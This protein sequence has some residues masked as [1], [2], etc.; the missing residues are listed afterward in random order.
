MIVTGTLPIPNYTNR[1]NVP[2]PLF[3]LLGN[4]TYD[5]GDSR[6][7]VTQLIDAP[8]RVVLKEAH[9]HELTMDISDRIWAL[10][11]TAVHKL[12]EDGRG[13]TDDDISEE[14][15]FLEI[16]GWKISGAIDL[17]RL[18]D[19][20]VGLID[21]KSTT[22]YA[23]MHEKP[24]W[25]N[26]LNML[27]ELVE[28]AK[29]HTITSLEICALLRDW[30]ASKAKFDSGYP[31]GP[32][33]RITI[34][35]WP[36]S[37]REAYMAERVKLHQQAVVAHDL[38]YPLIECTPT[39]MWEKPTVCAVMQKGMK[40]AKLY[41]DMAEAEAAMKP[42]ASLDVRFGQRLRCES[43]CEVNEWCE[44]YRRY[45]NGRGDEDNTE[46]EESVE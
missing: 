41:K 7:S 32:I 29:G 19:G 18:T 8:Q 25:E 46:D 34:P 36:V 15:I 17:Q 44:Q 23:V 21:W 28:K 1:H 26:Q 43:Y 20:T 24:E 40:R 22:C 39:E 9:D 13:F 45:K 5:R 6:R 33:Q 12:I 35:L 42:G 3:A 31:E 2:G 4:E 37:K 14:R 16:D 10:Y 30:S 27:A 38:G 11:G